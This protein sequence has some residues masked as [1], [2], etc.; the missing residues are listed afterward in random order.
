MGI[1]ASVLK[2][3]IGS[4]LRKMLT[5]KDK[6]SAV[7]E[8]ETEDIFNFKISNMSDDT[9]FKNYVNEMNLD[10]IEGI[11][12][13]LVEHQLAQFDSIRDGIEEIKDELLDD[14]I[15]EID[16]A[17]KSFALANREENALERN[18]QYAEAWKE[19]SDAVVRLRRK[20]ERNIAIIREVDELD[21]FNFL[22][23]ALAYEKKV[24]HA[25]QMAKC[26][27][28]AFIMGFIIM[29]AS[30]LI[31]KC[32][33]KMSLNGDLINEFKDELL[34]QDCLDLMNEYDDESDFWQTLSS[35][36]DCLITNSYKLDYL[37]SNPSYMSNVLTTSE[38]IDSYSEN[39]IDYDNVIFG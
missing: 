26:A 6:L 16:I 22:I 4:T 24:K 21:N 14:T 13:F 33:E 5:F 38:D 30:A 32:K 28:D 31:S 1:N 7:K 23:R 27:V 11:A 10:S 25:N 29:Q 3:K 8:D 20:I 18:K 39:N 19:A 15:S 36:L 37:L 17:R 34:N 2:E 35:K 9:D 12:K